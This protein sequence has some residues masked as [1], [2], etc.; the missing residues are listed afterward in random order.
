MELALHVLRDSVLGDSA[1]WWPW[2]VAGA[3]TI[4]RQGSHLV[5]LADAV[6]RAEW[7]ELRTGDLGR[8]R[9]Y[10]ILR[11]RVA[12][13]IR[14]VLRMEAGDHGNF[15]RCI[16]NCPGCGA[17]VCWME[18]RCAACGEPYRRR[19]ARPLWLDAPPHKETP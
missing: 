5:D 14:A 19:L 15:A 6:G 7:V 11:A 9:H 10:R 3:V 16:R 1:V 12:L 4:L 18:P 17:D 13:Y 8:R 2:C